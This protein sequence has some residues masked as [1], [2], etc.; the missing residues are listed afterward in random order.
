[1]EKSN[2]ISLKETVPYL[3]KESLKYVL[4]KK[5]RLQ[6]TVRNLSDPVLQG[7]IIEIFK[8]LGIE[9]KFAQ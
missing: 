3:L 5:S 8:E 7:E 1:M 2:L 4:N 9:V 6:H